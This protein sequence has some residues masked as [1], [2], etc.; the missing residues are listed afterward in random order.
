[1]D[2]RRRLFPF[3]FGIYDCASYPFGHPNSRV[4]SARCSECL[5]ARARKLHYEDKLLTIYLFC[6]LLPFTTQLAA[7]SSS[8]MLLP[9]AANRDRPSSD[10]MGS[11]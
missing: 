5:C 2:L 9:T 11:P 4:W 7:F 3:M 1:M 10:G 8:A 6:G